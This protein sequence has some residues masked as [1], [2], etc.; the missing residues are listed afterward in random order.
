M[1]IRQCYECLCGMPMNV[2]EKMLAGNVDG[3][4]IYPYSDPYTT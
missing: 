2:D 3:D 4:D 1:Q